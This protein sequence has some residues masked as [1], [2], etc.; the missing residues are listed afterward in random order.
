MR[1]RL[2]TQAARP[3][4][5]NEDFAAVSPSAAVLLDGAG[6]PRGLESGCVHGVAW[7]AR[8][9]GTTLLAETADPAGR[10]LADC[11]ARA[12][13]RVR[14][15]HEGACDLAHPG[16]PTATVVALRVLADQLEYLVLADSSLVLTSTSGTTEVVTD[17]RLDDVL[18]GTR[19]AIDRIPLSDPGYPA[20][21]SEHILAVRHLRNSPGGFWVASP[22]PAVAG[23]ALTGTR[24]LACL[25]SALL[26]SD[27]ASR[28]A[29]LFG[30]ASF[31]DLTAVA[32]GDDGPAELIR[33]VRA[34]EATDPDG[35]RWKRSKARDDATVVY[36]DQLAG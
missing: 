27:G 7:F 31:A 8:T 34:A 26:L 16:S 6:I 4:A 25:R 13:D 15:L 5:A 33:Q 18:Q 20:A 11:L 32:A 36:C 29:D 1:A 12:I 9:L 21:F 23:H 2:A 28:P 14:L 19:E 10:P 17:R 24:P 30:L 22:D 35:R 3:D